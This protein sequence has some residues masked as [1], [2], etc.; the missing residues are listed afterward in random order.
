M[1]IDKEGRSDKGKHKNAEGREI[2][3]EGLEE[4]REEISR[5]DQL[6]HLDSDI[7][8]DNDASDLSNQQDNQEGNYPILFKAKWYITNFYTL[9]GYEVYNN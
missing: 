2:E 9:Y 5:E 4:A 8:K 6:V 1:S 7:D 3:K